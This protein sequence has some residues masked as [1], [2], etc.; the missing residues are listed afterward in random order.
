MN[1]ARKMFKKILR[2]YFLQF[3]IVSGLALGGFYK[4]FGFSFHANREIGWIT[5]VIDNLSLLN[6]MKWHAFINIV[7][8]HIYGANAWGWY[9]TGFVF[10]IV[11]TCVLIIFVGKLTK[12]RLVGFLTGLWFVVSPA[13][14]DAVT[15]GSQESMYAAQL[16][17][18]F[19]SALFYKRFRERKNSLTFYFL[20]LFFFSIIIPLRESGLIYFPILV[21]FD[22][23]FYAPWEKL[24]NI[25]NKGWK[26]QKKVIFVFLRFLLPLI[27]FLLISIAYI[28]LRESYGGSPND[29]NDGR[30][31]FKSQL[32]TEGKFLEYFKYGVITFGFYIP[33]HLIPYPLLNTIR[34]FFTSSFT[35]NT[36]KIIFFPVIG[37]A[38][39]LLFATITFILRKEKYFK[40]LLFS[41]VLVVVPTIFYS[42]AFTTYE[43][44]FLREYIYEEHRWRYVAFTGTSLFIIVLLINLSKKIIKFGNWK[45]VLS[46]IIFLHLLTS[47]F[48]LWRIQDKMYVEMFREQKLFFRTFRTIFPDYKENY[49]LYFFPVSGRVGDYMWEWYGLKEYYHPTL[50][51]LRK[52]WHYTEMTKILNLLKKDRNLLSNMYFVDFDTTRGVIDYTRKAK[53]QIY[54]Q[55]KVTLPGIDGISKGNNILFK[56]N[57]IS[58]IEFPYTAKVTMS[59]QRIG[60]PKK[61]SEISDEKLEALTQYIRSHTVISSDIKVKEVCNTHGK[62]EI[63]DPIHLV[64]GNFGIRSTWFADCSPG[65]FILDLGS[66]KRISG[67]IMGGIKNDTHVPLRYSYEVSTDGSS[68]TKVMEINSNKNF[69]IMDKWPNVQIARYIRINVF[70]TQMGGFVQLDEAEPVLDIASDIF[71]LWTSRESLTNDMRGVL[72]IVSETQK[73]YIQNRGINL[74]FGRFSWKTNLAEVSEDQTSFYFPV[75]ADGVARTYPVPIYESEYYSLTTQFLKRKIMSIGLDFA[76]FPGEVKIDSIELIP[77]FPVYE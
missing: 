14:H 58:P 41:L 72:S 52:D 26:E 63:F 76:T 20:A 55:K 56:V 46:T 30:V 65:W 4:I 38:F 34:E 7:N 5:P 27:L 48:F 10:H 19:I 43:D 6:L 53:E 32:L 44:F 2:S 47:I 40:V 29:F 21:M 57:E 22:F 50:G 11:A 24:K 35:S 3:I 64:D 71:D 25:K 39:F 23:I 74:A 60:P 59:L 15:F 67:F 8:Y 36:P 31:K 75:I 13:W 69:E 62:M 28:L 73:E 66:E 70:T 18:F 37:Y 33:P 12:S 9:L 49:I 68:W 61:I 54:N 45:L 42:F 16:F 1:T 51:E 77:T 17:L